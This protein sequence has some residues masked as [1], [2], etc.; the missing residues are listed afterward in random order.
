MHLWL[1]GV[2]VPQGAWGIILQKNYREGDQEVEE[3]VNHL[4]FG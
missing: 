1:L 4:T 3:V 2:W